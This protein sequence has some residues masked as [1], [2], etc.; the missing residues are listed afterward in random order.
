MAIPTRTIDVAI[1]GAGPA[2]LMAAETLIA[3]GHKPVIF[4]AMPTA[5]RKFLMAGKSGLNLTHSEDIDAFTKRFG[6]REE[7]IATALAAFSPTD[8]R[9]WANGLGGETFVGSSGRIFPKAFKASPLLRAWLKKLGDGGAELLTRHKWVGWQKDGTLTFDTPDGP[10]SVSAQATVLALGGTSWPKLGSDGNWCAA[11]AD[12]SV[13]IVDFKPSNCGLNYAW[14]PY[15]KEH[16]AGGPVKGITLKVGDKTV[17]GDFVIS[18]YG[19][20]GSAIYT[21]SADVRNQ[22]ESTG[23]AE[24]EID[25][26]PD[27]SLERITQALAKPKGKKS[28]ATHIKRATGLIG[29]KANLVRECLPQRAFNDSTKL[30]QAVKALRIAVTSVRPIEEAISVAGGVAFGS[31]NAHLMLT[32][33]PGTFCAGEMLD[34]DAPT[35]GYLLSACFAQGKQAGTGASDWLQQQS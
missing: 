26:T 32:D 3:A 1:I 33:I 7:Q 22:I 21:V 29:V 16:F 31:L 17:K 28:M 2:G 30:A 10:I 9:A 25:L 15:F 8:I 27:R 34:W 20:E 11:L 14:S 12:K 5:G 24:L 13:D 18:G 6:A 4:E 35:G 19:M 23:K